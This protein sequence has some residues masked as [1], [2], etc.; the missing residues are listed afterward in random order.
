MTDRWKLTLLPGFD[1]TGQLFGPLQT[2]LGRLLSSAVRYSAERVL[3]DYT[4]FLQCR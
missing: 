4:M 3:D 2:A 1:G